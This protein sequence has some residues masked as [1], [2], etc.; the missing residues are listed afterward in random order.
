[1]SEEENIV[2]TEL[3]DRIV[4]FLMLGGHL[5]EIA[6]YCGVTRYRVVDVLQR[7][8]WRLRCDTN[9][10]LVAKMLGLGIVKNIY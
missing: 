7:L 6:R 5:K 9:T 3:E 8:R 2:L 1:M 10:Q 4:M